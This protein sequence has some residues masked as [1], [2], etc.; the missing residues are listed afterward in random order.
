MFSC[1]IMYHPF[2]NYVLSSL[3]DQLG[4]CVHGFSL[5]FPV[6]QKLLI[7]T[8]AASPALS[9]FSIHGDPVFSLSMTN[10]NHSEWLTHLLFIVGGKKVMAFYGT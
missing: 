8:M 5:A 6:K 10:Y 4:Q 2:D 3:D 7:K 1:E 9:H